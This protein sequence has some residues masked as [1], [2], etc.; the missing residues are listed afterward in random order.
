M[1]YFVAMI[2]LTLPVASY[3]GGPVIPEQVVSRHTSPADRK[4]NCIAW[5]ANDQST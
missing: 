2:I 1:R 5:A 4:Y 3:A